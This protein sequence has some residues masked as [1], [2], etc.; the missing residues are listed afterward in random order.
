MALSTG[1]ITADV[2]INLTGYARK[3]IALEWAIKSQHNSLNTDELIERAEAF[4]AF[5]QS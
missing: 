5:L 2:D 4:D 3:V 1:T